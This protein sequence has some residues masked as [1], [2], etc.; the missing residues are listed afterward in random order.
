MTPLDGWAIGPEDFIDTPD[1]VS[2]APCDD[3]FLAAVRRH[4][5][6]HQPVPPPGP[7]APIDILRGANLGFTPAQGRAL[8]EDHEG[9]VFLAKLWDAARVDGAPVGPPRVPERIWRLAEAPGEEGAITAQLL[10]ATG[11]ALP[12]DFG[13][14]LDFH[15]VLWARQAP[16]SV[17]SSA[18]SASQTQTPERSA[19]CDGPVWVEAREAGDAL[20]VEIRSRFRGR[21]TLVLHWPDG[22]SAHHE[23]PDLAVGQIHVFTLPGRAL[24]SSIQVNRREAS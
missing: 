13:Q 21:H 24:P 18:A 7:D 22:T 12:A 2:A 3:Q 23:T 4:Q 5:A 17:R 9:M 14:E 20:E 11:L 15:L 16:W 1:G 8:L 19:I 10:Q 6:R